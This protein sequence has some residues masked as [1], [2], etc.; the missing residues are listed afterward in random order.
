[1]LIL[2]KKNKFI[3]ILAIFFI[4]LMLLNVKTLAIVRSTSDFYVNDYASLLSFDTK[5][6]IINVNRNLYSQT[7]AQ[8]VVV[9]VQNLGGSSLEEYATELFREFGIGDRTKNNG[10]LLLLALEERE[11]RVEVG[12]GLEG[13]LPDGLTGRIQDE[14]IIPYL[15]QNNWNDGIRNGFNAILEIVANEYGVDVGAESAIIPEANTSAP[16]IAIFGIVGMPVISLIVGLILNRLKSKKNIKKKSVTMYSIIYFVIVIIASIITFSGVTVAN[17][18][19]EIGGKIFAIVFIIVFNL[20]WFSGGF[21]GTTGY[22]SGGYYRGYSS[23][24]SSGRSHSS[25]G[26][27]SGGGGRSGGG[28][29]SR[30]F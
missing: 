8:I 7:G 28:G 9:T 3:K 26:H 19:S 30:R 2:N 23:G 1:M 14:Y 29:S 16:G 5:N 10:V 11:F 13:A 6:Y 17:I 27:S 20:I 18:E 21:F 25:G 4:L 15:R 22:G 12:Y 24:H